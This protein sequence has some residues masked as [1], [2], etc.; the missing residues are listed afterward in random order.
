M[1]QTYITCRQC[2]GESPDDA[3]FCIECG[4]TLNAATG[5]TTKL[6]MPTCA[7]CGSENLPE[8]KFC[9]ICGRSVQAA[10]AAHPWA[11]PAQLPPAQLRPP[12]PV[13]VQSAP[14][15][16]VPPT[17]A[18]VLSQHAMQRKAPR[19]G[20]VN[21]AMIVVLVGIGVLFALKM[22]TVP[23]VLLVLATGYLIKQ[24]ERGRLEQSLKM[25]LIIGAGYLAMTNPRFWPM[26]IAAF[27]IMKIM[28][29]R[30]RV[31]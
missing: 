2:G 9:A 28:P 11:Q 13:P 8:A 3:R 24:A 7:G 30:G 19:S 21:P 6:P 20:G 17:I 27:I 10:T 1:V 26:W 29:P 15:T 18:P 25:V 4:E 12:R 22:V 31:F 5:A 23:L 16:I 14:R